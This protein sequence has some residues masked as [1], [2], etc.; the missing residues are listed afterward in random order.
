[1][2]AS[3]RGFF[4]KVPDVRGPDPAMGLAPTLL[5]K[6][7]SATEAGSDGEPGP[8]SHSSMAEAQGHRDGAMPQACWS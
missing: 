3:T 2:S 4:Q 5:A 8:L 1:M 7:S 6:Y